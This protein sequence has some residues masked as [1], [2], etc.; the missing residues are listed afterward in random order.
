MKLVQFRFV[1]II[2]SFNDSLYDYL[3]GPVYR[4]LRAGF[5]IP[6]VISLRD[7]KREDDR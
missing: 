4:I 3:D 6:F 1:P 5:T 7:L 2:H